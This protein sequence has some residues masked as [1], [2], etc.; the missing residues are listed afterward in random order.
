MSL[1]KLDFKLEDFTRV[2]WSTSNARAVWEPRI[3]RISNAWNHVERFA[4][5]A[6]QVVSPQSLPALASEVAQYGKIVLPLSIQGVAKTY[7]STTVDYKLGEAFA[8]RVA[9]IKEYSSLLWLQAWKEQNDVKI[10]KLLQ[11][12]TCCIKFFNKVWV[13]EQGL[14]TTWQMAINTEGSATLGHHI[15]SVKGPTYC[16]ILLRWLGLRMVSHLPC[17]F[18]CQFTEEIASR[19][20]MHFMDLGYKQELEWLIEILSWPMEWSALHGIAE[21]KTPI[22]KISSRTDSTPVKY[23]VRR[24]ATSY[25]LEGARGNVFPY[26]KELPRVINMWSENG[27]DSLGS[28]REAHNMI[29]SVVPKNLVNVI[30]LGCGNGELLKRIDCENRF[31][32]DYRSEAILAAKLHCPEGRF[33]QSFIKNGVTIANFPDDFDLALISAI[34]MKEISEEEREWLLQ[35]IKMHVKYLVV[36]AYVDFEGTFTHYF[37]GWEVKGVKACQGGRAV[38][39]EKL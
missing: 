6:L 28:M 20:F 26:R 21:I 16:N 31:G 12:P 19:N 33:E 7:S 25:P 5:P 32:V 24:N 30:D 4:G 3:R 34:R 13:E 9:I 8:Y 17:S 15:A 11:Y 29:L 36:Y 38:L 2:I 18:N 10:G 37:P 23:I 14:D 22:L 27:F 35:N 1:R 39:M